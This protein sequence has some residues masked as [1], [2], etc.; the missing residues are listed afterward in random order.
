LHNWCS[1]HNEA[2]YHEF[3][4]KLEAKVKTMF[5]NVQITKN[6]P[7][8]HYVQRNNLSNLSL[9]LHRYLNQKSEEVVAFPRHGAFEI[10]VN[11]M[12]IF[13]KIQSNLWPNIEKV[14]SIIALI[15]NEIDNGRDIKRFSLEFRLENENEDENFVDTYKKVLKFKI[16]KRPFSSQ[17]NATSY[18]SKGSVEPQSEI[19]NSTFKRRNVV[20][21][22]K[23]GIER[24]EY[25]RKSEFERRPNPRLR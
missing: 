10:K 4:E 3:Y 25:S 18:V 2:K 8:E 24:L 15:K 21:L 12:L 13:S 6:Q 1:R 11:G 20:S 22:K 7:P 14:V 9:G 5:R 23:S 17:F 19:K 16:N